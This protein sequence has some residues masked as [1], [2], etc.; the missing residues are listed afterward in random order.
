MRTCNCLHPQGG[1]FHSQAGKI[2]CLRELVLSASSF[3]AWLTAMSY[4]SELSENAPLQ[5]SDIQQ[6]EIAPLQ[7][8]VI[9]EP[10]LSLRKEPNR[11]FREEPGQPRFN[12]LPA[13]F[14]SAIERNDIIPGR[15]DLRISLTSAC[16]LRC[17]YCHNEGQEAPW[18]QAKT[19]AMLGN[20]EKLLET[21][22]RYD[23]QSVKFSGGDPG[24]YPGF[25][26]LMDTIA[27]WRERFPSIAKWG[28]CTNGV[29]FVDAEKFR[30]LVASRLDNISIGIDSV[31][32]GERSKP[33]SPV[34]ISGTALIDKFVLPLLKHWSDAAQPDLKR[35]IKFDTV[36]TGDKH[37]TLNVV[38]AARRLGVSV[39]VVEI[40]G[41]M[42]AVHTVRSKFLDLIVETAEEF[43]LQHRLYKPLNEFYLYDEQGNAP[44]KFYQDHCRDLDCGNCRKIHLRVSPTP[45]GWGAVPCFLRAQSQTI[46]LM[47]DG[48]FADARFED[49]I[50]HNGR[51][52][53]WFKGTPYDPSI[54]THTRMKT[55]ASA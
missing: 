31:E 24:V 18:L 10:C 36:F 26:M 1:Q 21:A 39:S 4:S 15:G 27:G 11:P 2:C 45:Q 55:D 20:I 19:S 9:E 5:Q 13:D 12:N 47:R 50:K 37:R 16:N 30:A 54:D 8:E 3:G 41:V 6:S 40:N 34:G 33:S 29:P 49:A 7:R 38:R 52:P 28:M 53:Q 42:G 22:T 48:E 43:G 44:I 25:F 35:S 17:S 23:V 46:P 51:G 14:T 32:P